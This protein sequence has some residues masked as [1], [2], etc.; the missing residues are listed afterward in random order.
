M[1][2]SVA[3]ETVSRD[4]AIDI[5]CTPC[6]I[7]S[8]QGGALRAAILDPPELVENALGPAVQAMRKGRAAR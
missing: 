4:M 2:G 1:S 6:G 5:A 7:G 8:D 3:V